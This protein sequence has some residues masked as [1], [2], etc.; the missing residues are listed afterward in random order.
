M[1]QSVDDASRSDPALLPGDVIVEMDGESVT[2]LAQVRA[3]LNA[4]RVG[5]EIPL[6]VYRDGAYLDV[7]LTLIERNDMS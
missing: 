6:L 7:T 2:T 3:L 1:I 5:D 4:R